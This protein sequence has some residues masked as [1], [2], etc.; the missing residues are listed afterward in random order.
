MLHYVWY[1]SAHKQIKKS[2]HTTVLYQARLIS[3][4]YLRQRRFMEVQ[5]Q[6][7]DHIWEIPSVETHNVFGDPSWSITS[8]RQYAKSPVYWSE[9]VLYVKV[10]EDVT[11]YLLLSAAHSLQHTYSSSSLSLE[12][13]TDVVG[14]GSRPV[15]KQH[16]PGL[17]GSG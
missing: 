11:G 16:L 1:I 14:V 4:T 6:P 15:L 2:I 9:L 13:L 12:P 3:L 8:V 5:L 7:H 17:T 10:S